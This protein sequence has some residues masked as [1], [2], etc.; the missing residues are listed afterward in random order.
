MD[1]VVATPTTIILVRGDLTMNKSYETDENLTDKFVC[2]NYEL[3]Q[4]E[5]D[6]LYSN[7]IVC[8]PPILDEIEV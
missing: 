4:E 1:L 8:L 6:E 3:T 7:G 5:I 2:I